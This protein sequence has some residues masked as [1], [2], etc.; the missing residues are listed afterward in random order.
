MSSGP[1]EQLSP[2]TSIFSAVSVVRTAEMSVP[3]SILP[4]L[5]SSETEHWIGSVRAGLGER[6]A[7]A[8]DRCLHLED[9]LRRLDDDQ[10]GAAFDEPLG[11]LR[12][13]VGERA[14]GDVAERRVVGR[15]QEAGRPDRAGDEATLAGRLA[16]DLCCLH[17]DLE[18]VL[19]ESPLLELQPRGLEGVGL[20][21]LRAGV[22]HRRV[23]AFDDVGTVEH[24]RLVA[25]AGEPAVVLLSQVEL[26]KRRAHPAIE[27]DDALAD[28]IEVV[29]HRLILATRAPTLTRPWQGC[30]RVRRA[31]RRA[32][33]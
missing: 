12:E 1:V 30:V 18:R 20:D 4:P 33:A 8:E 5:G 22:E 10:V 24:E 19:A 29:A 11:L 27:D 9:V 16:R 26:L 21:D 14:E 13:D 31:A 28:G 23:D 25:L 15:G 3:S 32:R 2:I 7:C 6:L 17:V